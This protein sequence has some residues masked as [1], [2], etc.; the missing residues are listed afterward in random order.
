MAVVPNRAALGRS[1]RQNVRSGLDLKAYSSRVH[2]VRAVKIC[3]RG[4]GGGYLALFTV[5]VFAGP[6]IAVRGKTAGDRRSRAREI[7]CSDAS[8]LKHLTGR[9]CMA[10]LR[11]SGRTWP[12]G[13]T[14][15]PHVSNMLLVARL[16][17]QCATLTYTV[18]V[19]SSRR[20]SLAIRTPNTHRRDEL[21]PLH[22]CYRS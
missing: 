9:T 12:L 4:R 22:L 5:D 8:R 6:R 13:C 18:R 1:R 21:G 15:G 3:P 17:V 11:S 10:A 7:N 14:L 19:R 2:S 16:F 20:P